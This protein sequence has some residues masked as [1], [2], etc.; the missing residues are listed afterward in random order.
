MVLSQSEY[1][2]P[3]LPQYRPET[4]KVD[5]PN[6]LQRIELRNQPRRRKA[7]LPS[8]VQSPQPLTSKRDRKIYPQRLWTVLHFADTQSRVG[9][10][11]NR[12]RV[13][14]KYG[15]ENRSYRTGN[16]RPL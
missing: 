7:G 8:K 2:L 13:A 4:L 9:R 5:F 1:I 12:W 6:L 15:R 3:T 11:E 14:R 16:P 10:S